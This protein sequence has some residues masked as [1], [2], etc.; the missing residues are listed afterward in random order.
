MPRALITLLVLGLATGGA[1][2][3]R[4]DG[5]GAPVAIPLVDRFADEAIEDR[6]P[7]PAPPR[8]EWRFAALAPGRSTTAG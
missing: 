7:L 8:S 3:L 2:L 5:A 6:R 1:L 4:R